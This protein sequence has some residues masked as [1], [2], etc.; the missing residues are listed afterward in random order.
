MKRL[1][2]TDRAGLRLRNA[3]RRQFAVDY[4]A[5][6]LTQ[7]RPANPFEAAYKAA[8]LAQDATALRAA[9]ALARVATDVYEVLAE[10]LATLSQPVA[11]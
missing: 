3:A 5:R 4:L 1:S 8:T 6:V 2:A 9:I 11:S 10:Q 7:D